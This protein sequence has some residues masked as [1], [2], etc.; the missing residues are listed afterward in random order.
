MI[1]FFFLGKRRKLLLFGVNWPTLL[2]YLLLNL[3]VK[4]KVKRGHKTR[5]SPKTS[6]IIG[7]KRSGNTTFYEKKFP[8]NRPAQ[9]WQSH[10]PVSVKHIWHN[11]AVF[12]CWNSE[13]YGFVGTESHIYIIIPFICHSNFTNVCFQ[14]AVIRQLYT[15]WGWPSL[16][17]V[18]VLLCL[19][20]HN[21]II[22]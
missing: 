7:I 8:G 12:F 13:L 2:S 22:T 21:W 18:L 17:N 6:T 10:R 9:T 5:N 19:Q 4:S 16:S 3:K 20:Y 11:D 15:G 14:S 1:M